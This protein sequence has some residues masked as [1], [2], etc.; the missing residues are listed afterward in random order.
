MENKIEKQINEVLKR[1]GW[2]DCIFV[3]GGNE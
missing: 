1:I 3:K 2:E